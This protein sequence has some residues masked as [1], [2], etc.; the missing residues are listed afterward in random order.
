MLLLINHKVDLVQINVH[1][2]K[3]L[4]EIQP[5]IKIIIFQIINLM[6]NKQIIRKTIIN[7]LNPKI[8]KKLKLLKII[9]I[10]KN[11]L[12]LIYQNLLENLNKD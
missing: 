8:K 3:V 12:V 6:M 9:M 10:I 5:V 11:I 1:Y 2:K 7:K 4:E